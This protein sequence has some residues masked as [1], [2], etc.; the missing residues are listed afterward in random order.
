V[1][2]RIKEFPS[3]LKAAAFLWPADR[4]RAHNSHV[5]IELP[6]TIRNS[7]CAISEGGS[8]AVDADD[9]RS[10]E[11]R[12]VEVFIQLA[13]GRSLPGPIVALANFDFPW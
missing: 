1:I 5:D 8:D 3:E 7:C 4:H 2:Q 12:C 9:R 13:A 6:R 11:T 10:S